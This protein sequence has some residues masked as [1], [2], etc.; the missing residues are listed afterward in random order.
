LAFVFEANKD[1]TSYCFVS[2]CQRW[3]ALSSTEAASE[4]NQIIT[5]ASQWQFL[6]QKIRF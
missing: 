2:F 5:D 1:R 4:S 3:S 6:C